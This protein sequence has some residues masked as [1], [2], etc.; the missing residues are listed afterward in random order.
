MPPRHTPLLLSLA[1]LPAAVGGPE[2]DA[3]PLHDYVHR[4]D[5][6][7]THRV[8]RIDDENGRTFV[9]ELTS[10]SWRSAEEVSVPEWTHWMT[11][12]VPREL[13]H[14]TPLLYVAGG[15]RHA[16]P[17]TKPDPL[18]MRF[19]SLVG[20]PVIYLPNVPNQPLVF[21][22]DDKPKDHREDAIISES[23]LRYFDTG[24]AEWVVQLAMVKSVVA[25]M[26]AA[27]QVLADAEP[28]VDAAE[29]IVL[30]G[31]KRGWTTWLA[32]AV[33]DR[34]KAIVPAV[35]DMLNMR[36]SM[37]HHRAAYGFF[38]PALGDYDERGILSQLEDPRG[39]RL[40]DM[41]DPY[42]RRDSYT[43]PKFIVNSA[44]DEFF[45]PDSAKFYFNEMPDP[46]LL[47]YTP[48]VD[49]GLSRIDTV[50]TIASFCQHV[51]A[52]RALPTVRWALAADATLRV[53]TDLEPS[54]A[55]LW[56]AT[57]PDARD[58]RLETIGAA[59]KPTPVDISPSGVGFECVASLPTPEHGWSAS[60]I[61]LTFPGS[62]LPLICSTEVFV[63]PDVLPHAPPDRG[64]E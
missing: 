5:P 46:K 25:A 32:A 38:A 54:N 53:T 11:I 48:N 14:E 18:A 60:L 34:V 44:G 43:L 10:Q 52:E 64:H 29:F 39:E 35:I 47:R 42:R 41:V 45:L 37:T 26:D 28:P 15:R 13:R 23:W 1:L 49:H 55:T 3:D 20:A 31:S 12:T 17:P 8:E 63:L 36:E 16:N 59:Y 2:R 9:V 51:L 4:S 57:N 56:T 58:F 30:G 21:L 27:Q 7:T 22:D 40:L 61:E 6:T 50:T 24:D 33:D 19:A 62:P